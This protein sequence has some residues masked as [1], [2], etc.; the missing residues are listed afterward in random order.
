MW[1]PWRGCH[2]CSEGCRYCYIHKGDAR[3]GVDTDLI[4]KGDKF[5]APVALDK[6]GAYKMKGG[7]TVFTCFQSDFLLEDADPWRGECWEMIARRP[8][9]SFLFLTKRIER[10]ADCA[11]EDWGEGYD[12]VVVGCTVENRETARY[13]LGIFDALPIKH[14]NIICQPLLEEIDL[15]EH[16]NGVELVVVGGESDQNARALDYEWVLKIRSQCEARKVDFQFR[17]CG[18]NFIKDGVSYRLN[19]RQLCQQAR[20]ADIDLKFG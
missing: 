11:P 9:L 20:K 18:T 15:T 3:R 17:Q 14:K 16:L 8:D 10:F 19:V 5:G 7:Q 6:K 13:K 12:N 1:S 2:K 4:V